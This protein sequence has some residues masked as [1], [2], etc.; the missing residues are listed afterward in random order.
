MATPSQSAKRLATTRESFIGR[1][2]EL[3][4]LEDRLV[5]AGRGEG[6]VIFISGE[7]GI[8]KSR[9]LAELASRARDDG[10]LVLNGSAYETE[11]VPPYVPFAEAISQYLRSS[12]DGEAERRLAVAAREVALL[13]PE[14][15]DLV[16]A[17][18][19]PSFGP[20]A[21]RYRL[22][23]AVSGFLLA[24]S[25]SSEA[26]G[27]L[28]C[29]D[30]LHWADQSSLLLFLH[31]ARKLEGAR[32]L[33]VAAFR[34]EEV[35]AANA[36]SDVLAELARRGQEQ[37]L[38]LGRLSLEETGALV[39][40]LG[41]TAAPEQVDAVYQQTEGNPFFVQEVVRHVKGLAAGQ[42]ASDALPES[43][44][45][46]IGQR[47]SRLDVV[48]RGLLESAAVL[49]DGFELGVLRAMTVMRGDDV[50]PALEASTQAGM[51]REHGGGYVFGHPLIRQVIYEGLSLPRRQTLHLR[52]AAAIQV[53]HT[54][55]LDAQL[56][57]L[58]IHYGLSGSEP[59]KTIDFASRAGDWSGEV[60]AFDEALGLYD[61]AIEETR[62]LGGPASEVAVAELEIKRGEALSALGRWPEARAAFEAAAGALQGERRAD[63]LLMLATAGT[64]GP[65]DV[66]SARRHAAMALDAAREVGREDLEINAQ[67]LLAQC[68]QAE[69]NFKRSLTEYN[70][71]FARARDFP[72]IRPHEVFSHYG[73]ALYYAGRINEAV[74]E[75]RK[76]AVSAQAAH[77]DMMSVVLLGDLGVSLTSAGLYDEAL[78]TFAAARNVARN[79]GATGVQIPLARTVGMSTLVHI[80]TADFTRAEAIAEK[81]REIAR[82]MDFILPVVSEGIDLITISIRRGDFS[83]VDDLVHDVMANLDK[84][85]GAHGA[86]WLTRLTVARAEL[87]LARAQWREALDLAGEAAVL[88]GDLGRPKYEALALASQ[89]SALAALGRKKEALSQF[90]QAAETARPIGDPSLFLQIACA[91]LAVEGN[92]V[93]LSDAGRSVER[94]LA[95]LSDEVMR[96]NFEASAPVQAVYKL[97]GGARGVFVAEKP[98]YPDGLTEREVEVL[99]LLARGKSSRE[100]G[101]ELVLSVRTVE[102][103]IANI[104]LK[105]DT[106]GRAQATAYALAKG[107]V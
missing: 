10:W 94:I 66:P 77:R 49:G 45:Q 47:L 80:A 104:Y 8:G 51:L 28:L 48:T 69:G 74:E 12:R 16:Q 33:V 37:R 86:L 102:R 60:Y 38:T 105:T 100:I 46:V 85:G 27:L 54:G 92:D 32:I 42:Q 1:Q 78:Q 71:A 52:A 83:R 82:S 73:L 67:A 2:R 14:L 79:Y 7:P 39:A 65:A 44:R 24:L 75:G 34:A 101:E 25:S 5:A 41:Y 68:D 99:R 90:Q 62:R 4:F 35:D 89:G 50:T 107:F 81:A 9:L 72:T 93:L 106:H 19:A 17:D 31:L 11:G 87:A 84:G 26:T 20:Q 18:K 30:D 96:R 61:L 53:V 98:V 40:S 56:P 58:A 21:D 70:K 95:N 55:R 88:A 63:V 43:I 13:V 59:E 29:L 15:S 76:L 36:L 57:T 97:S 3:A 6:G 64:T 103:H 91:Q 23:E 22:F